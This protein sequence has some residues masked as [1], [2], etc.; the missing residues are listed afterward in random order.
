MKPTISYHLHNTSTVLISINNSSVMFKLASEI[1][2]SSKYLENEYTVY[3][4][5]K[6]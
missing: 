5:C 3:I 2:I 6:I 4:K 1:I